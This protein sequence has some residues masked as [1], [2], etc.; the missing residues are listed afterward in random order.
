[1]QVRSADGEARFKIDP[2][3]CIENKG[4]KNKDVYLAESIIEENKHI[5]LAR[6]NGFFKSITMN[7]FNCKAVKCWVANGNIY[8]KLDN[9]KE[10]NLPIERFGLLAKANDAQLQNV[11]IIDGYALHWPDLDEDLSVAGF[12]ATTPEAA[13]FEIEN[14]IPT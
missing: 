10:A 13:T 4:L 11:K 5:F 7:F 2:L 14:A 6:W 1:M 3:N 12:F 9:G 8:V